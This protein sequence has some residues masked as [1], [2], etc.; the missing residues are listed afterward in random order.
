MCLLQL[1]EAVN[2]AMDNL[3]SVLNAKQFSQFRWLLLRTISKGFVN[4][5]T[6]SHQVKVAVPWLQT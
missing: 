6:Q 1:R 2:E 5:F 4:P 3:A